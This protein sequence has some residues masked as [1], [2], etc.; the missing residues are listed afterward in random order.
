MVNLIKLSSLVVF[1]N[2]LSLNYSLAQNKCASLFSYKAETAL[3]QNLF[4]LQLNDKSSL[5][6]E[7]VKLKNDNAIE[8]LKNTF[9]QNE[10]DLITLNNAHKYFSEIYKSTSTPSSSKYDR[11][12]VSIGYCF[13]RAMYY[14]LLLLRNKV[15]KSHIKKIWV[16]GPMKAYGTDWQFHVA[17][18][19][20]LKDNNWYAL[21]T[22][23]NS[24]LEVSSWAKKYLAMGDG[25]V[26]VFITDPKKFTP[27]LTYNK[28]QF[29][30]NLNGKD[31]WYKGYFQDMLNESRG[32]SK[33][34]LKDR[35]QLNSE[36]Q[37]NATLYGDIFKSLQIFF[38]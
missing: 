35:T 14:H 18:I 31:D 27:S 30:L 7:D 11:S 4:Q 24:I 3:D 10:N 9:E 5:S 38:N 6:K 17:T 22:N 19:V 8:A 21:D 23:E 34:K 37:K 12:E 2:L 15:S 32:E 13:G 26:R 29:G 1:L 36:T 25:T 28:V 20:K 33:I 16:V